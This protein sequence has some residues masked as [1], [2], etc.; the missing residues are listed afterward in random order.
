MSVIFASDFERLYRADTSRLEL[1]AA[2][3]K[4]LVTNSAGELLRPEAVEE[5]E[6]RYDKL[7]STVTRLH[8]EISSIQKRA[9]A[10]PAVAG[11][12]AEGEQHIAS[13][14][15]AFAA[16]L[17]H[18]MRMQVVW[19]R[20]QVDKVE[21]AALACRELL[22]GDKSG[23]EAPAPMASRVSAEEYDSSL[24]SQG[25]S[26]K[27]K[28]KK[29]RGLQY[30]AVAH[31]REIGG[32]SVGIYKTWRACKERVE[33]FPNCV[34]KGFV[35]EDEAE[36]WLSEELDHIADRAHSASSA[37]RHDEA[38]ARDRQEQQRQAAI[39]A[40]ERSRDS[41]R[42]SGA[43]GI[44]R[45]ASGSGWDDSDRDSSS[46]DD[47]SGDTGGDLPSVTF[48]P[49]S[50]PARSSPG[51]P[52]HSGG[53]SG[54][55]A[56]RTPSGAAAPPLLAYGGARG[57]LSALKMETQ[58]LR[59][60]MKELV[61]AVKAA[62][63]G[64]AV[65]AGYIGNAFHEALIPREYFTE[66]ISDHAVRLGLAGKMASC[67]DKDELKLKFF[68]SFVGTAMPH[69][70]F[71]EFVMSEYV[72]KFVGLESREKMSE[73]KLFSDALGARTGTGN[74]HTDHNLR[75]HYPGGEKIEKLYLSMFATLND[76]RLFALRW[77]EYC[78]GILERQD[79]EAVVDDQLFAVGAGGF[80]SGVTGDQ[81]ER[82]VVYTRQMTTHISGLLNYA[83]GLVMEQEAQVGSS[84]VFTTKAGVHHWEQVR[85]KLVSVFK[86]M[87]ALRRAHRIRHE[88]LFAV[89]AF[90]ESCS[91]KGWQIPRFDRTSL[92]APV[93]NPK[94]EALAKKI[95]TKDDPI[96]I[97]AQLA[98]KVAV[99]EKKNEVLEKRLAAQSN[100][101]PDGYEALKTKLANLGTEMTALQGKVGNL[102]KDGKGK[103]GKGRDRGGRP[104]GRGRGRGRG[105][106]GDDGGGEDGGDDAADG[107]ADGEADDG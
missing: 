95:G 8:R 105:G 71:G 54:D 86:H 53:R 82:C 106:G 66:Q 21:Q 25:S 4:A 42:G 57:E 100:A 76:L 58:E 72:L 88:G 98:A 77:A 93:P 68:R 101:T 9:M 16:T 40:E 90:L 73:L 87:F 2:S 92:F 46:G 44:G 27:S 15:T 30:Y 22:R 37:E 5:V 70:L 80:K 47:W 74:A 31:G 7:L 102:R 69:D 89:L 60:Q 52:R 78:K 48:S 43:D 64:P 62:P 55:R 103:D 50:T 34:F 63:R 32:C 45:G 65:K 13:T 18:T 107:A 17:E 79:P 84:T 49:P 26:K 14:M 6:G 3:R 75:H 104:R 96:Q 39:R 10:R 38:Q 1:Y 41:S 20:K 51:R 11:S 56:G 19:L 59:E 23:A 85:A 36:A 94:L 61:A 33:G 35:L 24:G 67:R 28:K 99:M 29:R 12:V 81:Q 83:L 91:R 97:A